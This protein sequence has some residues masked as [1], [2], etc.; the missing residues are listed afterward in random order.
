MGFAFYH[1][2]DAEAAIDGNGLMFAFGATEPGR[3]KYP[4]AAVA[5]GRRL[6]ERLEEDGLNPIWDSSL[7]QRIGLPMTWQRCRPTA[8]A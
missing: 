6:V 4:Q 2:Q 8:T 1:E 5:V 3:D 7:Q